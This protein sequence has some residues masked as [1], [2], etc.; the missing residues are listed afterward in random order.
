MKK[1][2]RILIALVIGLGV[3]FIS[4]YFFEKN[5]DITAE[6]DILVGINE[7]YQFRD[8]ESMEKASSIEEAFNHI[9][10]EE[11]LYGEGIIYNGTQILTDIEMQ[12]G[13]NTRMEMIDFLHY[14][15][16]SE[17]TTRNSVE[18][19]TPANLQDKYYYLTMRVYQPKKPGMNEQKPYQMWSIYTDKVEE[20]D[21]SDKG[22][23]LEE[24]HKYGKLDGT[25]SFEM[26]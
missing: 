24:I 5:K 9:F 11:R 17:L 15:Q 20:M 7:S 25:N 18:N 26:N 10:G 12:P 2:A 14:V 1:H 3:G 4:G 21:F 6:K 19:L 13:L 22:T 16:F 23:M 8:I